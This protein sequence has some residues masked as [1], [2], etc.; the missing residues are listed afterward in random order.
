MANKI[1]TL[2]FIQAINSI[3]PEYKWRREKL[4]EKYRCRECK[5]YKESLQKEVKDIYLDSK[6][7]KSAMFTLWITNI[8]FARWD[9]LKL[10]ENEARDYL[11]YGKVFDKEGRQLEDMATYNADFRV[12]L[13]G[14]KESEF[15]GI[16]P[17]CGKYKYTKYYPFYV[18]EGSL[19]DSPIH[20]LWKHGGILVPEE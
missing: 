7:D 3:D 4:F 5:L 13:R 17:Q 2:Y 10:F 9:F 12:P 15:I 20:V 18:L 14:K 6:P 11:R 8:Y 16:C 1:K 19:S